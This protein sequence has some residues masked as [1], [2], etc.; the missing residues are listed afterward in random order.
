MEVWWLTSSVPEAGRHGLK[1]REPRSS[2]TLPGDGYTQPLRRVDGYLEEAE[3]AES[4]RTSL[5]LPWLRGGAEHLQPHRTLHAPPPEQSHVER[6]NLPKASRSKRQEVVQL[7]PCT[8]KI[9]K[10]SQGSPL[11][12]IVAW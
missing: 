10:V 2:A 8:V 11:V 7:Q 6:E 9:C 12:E 3:G 1:G 5:H 4:E